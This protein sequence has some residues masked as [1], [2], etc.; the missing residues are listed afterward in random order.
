M[1][2]PSTAAAGLKAAA[3]AGHADVVKDLLPEEFLGLGLSFPIE[4]GQKR[5]KPYETIACYIN[6]IFDSQ[7]SSTIA[8]Y[9]N[10][11]FFC[12]RS[13]ACSQTSTQKMAQSF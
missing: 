3:T 9:Y 2:S 5:W 12:V 11:C 4:K 13:L 1:A 6:V 8:G 10:S 7:P